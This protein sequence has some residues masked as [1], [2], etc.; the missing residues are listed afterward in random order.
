MEKLISTTY[1]VVGMKTGDC[2]TDLQNILTDI[3][4]IVSVKIDSAKSQVQITS[5]EIIDIEMLQRATVKTDFYITELKP[6]Y[7]TASPYRS[8]V[9]RV[10]QKHHASIDV[11]GEGDGLL[12]SGPKTDY[13]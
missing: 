13:T 6:H 2:A 11:E 3:D 10:K 12:K 9:D 8:A 5:K 7:N 4:D 1:S